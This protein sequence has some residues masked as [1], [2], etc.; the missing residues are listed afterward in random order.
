MPRRSWWADSN[1]PP[2][3][4][5]CRAAYGTLYFGATVLVDVDHSMRVMRE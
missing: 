2:E 4:A 5:D 3:Q 1:A